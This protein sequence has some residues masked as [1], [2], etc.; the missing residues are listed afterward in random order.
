MLLSLAVVV[1]ALKYGG[2]IGKGTLAQKD[3]IRRDNVLPDLDLGCIQF[4]LADG[5]MVVI[6]VLL[7][8]LAE[9]NPGPGTRGCTSSPLIHGHQDFV[10]K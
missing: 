2:S 8:Q 5:M 6:A 1:V 4:Q 7:I 10:S 3:H 9:C